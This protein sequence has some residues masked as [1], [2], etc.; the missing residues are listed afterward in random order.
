MGGITIALADDGGTGTSTHT[1]DVEGPPGLHGPFG[2]PDG[3]AAAKL[4][5]KLG[6]SE[7]KVTDAFAAIREDYGPK[8]ADRAKGERPAPPTEAER[9]ALQTKMAAALA[10][11]LGVD[12]SAVEDA[13]AE[14][15]ADVEADVRTSLS[16]RLDDVVDA[17]DL[18]AADKAS[19]LKAYDAGVLGFGPVGFGH[20]GPGR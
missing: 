19:V 9:E 10:K 12:A 11:E 13:L 5:E 7:Q 14:L 18:T 16:D 17:G 15:R 6:V 1:A 4:A 8:I 2:G 20:G 3:D